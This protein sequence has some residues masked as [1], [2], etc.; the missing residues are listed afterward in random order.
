MLIAGELRGASRSE[1]ALLSQNRHFLFRKLAHWLSREV[2]RA[3]GPTETIGKVMRYVKDE[4]SRNKCRIPRFVFVDRLT[5]VLGIAPRTLRLWTKTGR[6]PACDGN[7]HGR[8]F[9]LESTVK[10]WQIDALK[11][12]FAEDRRGWL[13]PEQTQRS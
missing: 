4:E 6:F 3:V 11:G 9:W 7:V 10:R 12:H 2:C 13:S 5:E 8:N 1:S